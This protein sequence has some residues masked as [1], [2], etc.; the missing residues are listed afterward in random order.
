MV[1]AAMSYERLT[2]DAII[3]PLQ[4][5]VSFMATRLDLRPSIEKEHI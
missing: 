5:L 4:A 2:G 3:N 1:K